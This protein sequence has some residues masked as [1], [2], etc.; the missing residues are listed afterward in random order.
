MGDDYKNLGALRSYLAHNRNQIRKLVKV[1]EGLQGEESGEVVSEQ[2]TTLMQ[3]RERIK[4]IIEENESTFSILGW[5]TKFLSGYVDAPIDDDYLI[6]DVGD[7]IDDLGG[8]VDG[9][10]GDE[11]PEP[12]GTPEPAESPEPTILPT[13]TISPTVSPT[14]GA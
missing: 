3:E 7:V 13:P 14:P 12:T 10:E 5:I 6:D 8:G 2:L 11:D 9:D 1:S 4:T